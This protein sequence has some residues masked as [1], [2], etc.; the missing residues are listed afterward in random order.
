[1]TS[2]KHLRHLK[3]AM[4]LLILTLLLTACS[5]DDPASP[6]AGLAVGDIIDI[7]MTADIEISDILPAKDITPIDLQVT[8][9][10]EIIEI[11]DDFVDLSFLPGKLMDINVRGLAGVIDIYDN[12]EY[13]SWCCL[14]RRD[15][16]GI[17]L[18]VTTGA[19]S[20]TI[21]IGDSSR[22][23]LGGLLDLKE[24]PTNK[25]QLVPGLAEIP[26]LNMFFGG[27]N[28]E[29]TTSNLIISLTPTII[30]DLN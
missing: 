15:S 7:D 27:A 23:M 6:A 13:K 25:D 16:E 18:I 2:S 1:M 29:V 28:N 4:F 19:L 8:I 12:P 5:S 24:N 3:L 17:P 21:Q 11:G 10:A 9:K 14:S 22:M 26:A 20:M 30:A